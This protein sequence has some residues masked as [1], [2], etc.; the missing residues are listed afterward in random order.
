MVNRP[1]AGELERQVDRASFDA[2]RV[3]AQ[4]TAGVVIWKKLNDMELQDLNCNH[5]RKDPSPQ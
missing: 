2:R 3:C 1:I 5:H 4:A